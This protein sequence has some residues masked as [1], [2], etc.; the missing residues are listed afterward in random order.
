MIG[1]NNHESL[2][3]LKGFYNSTW[4]SVV[5]AKGLVGNG[6]CGMF[7]ANAMSECCCHLASSEHGG[8]WHTG[9]FRHTFHAVLKPANADFCV[10]CNCDASTF[11]GTK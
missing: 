2:S 1:H 4:V 11:M 5:E 7:N 9:Q 10:T 6:L 3:Q 8:I